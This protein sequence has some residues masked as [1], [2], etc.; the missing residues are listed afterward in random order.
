MYT[1]AK[2]RIY[3]AGIYLLKVNNE[4]SRTRCVIWKRQRNDLIDMRTLRNTDVPLVSLY[5][6]LVFHSW[7]SG[8]GDG[9]VNQQKL[10]YRQVKIMKDTRADT[11]YPVLI[12]RVKLQHKKKP[13]LNLRSIESVGFQQ[14]FT[15]FI[16]I[17]VPLKFLYEKKNRGR[18]HL[19]A[20]ND[21]SDVRC[22]DLYL[23][24]I[25]IKSA[26]SERWKD[27]MF[28]LTLCCLSVTVEDLN[29]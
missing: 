18:N 8:S 5:L 26:K 10:K 21:I 9:W 13:V 22:F 6:F 25:F 15:K 20:I 16:E 23:I 4:N 27:I 12:K 2:I 11:N 28:K 17:F 3:T 7:T 19:V 24:N 29:L 1:K 14:T